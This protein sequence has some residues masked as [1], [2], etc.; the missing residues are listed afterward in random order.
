MFIVIGPIGKR[1]GKLLRLAAIGIVLLLI[2]L[3]AWRIMGMMAGGREA[4]IFLDTVQRT[5]S[6]WGETGNGNFWQRWVGSLQR[7]FSLGF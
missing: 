1:W 6:N 3:I 2:A 5:M 7:W 4:D